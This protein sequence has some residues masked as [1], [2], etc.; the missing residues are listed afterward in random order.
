MRRLKKMRKALSRKKK[1][2]II[3][4]IN[5]DDYSIPGDTE[6]NSEEEISDDDGSDNEITTIT[7]AQPLWTLPL[8][9]LLPS[10]KQQ[11]CFNRPLQAAGCAW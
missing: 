7:N 5:L 10:H 6:H 2:K 9:S 8:Y 4:K 11:K 3:P 1:L